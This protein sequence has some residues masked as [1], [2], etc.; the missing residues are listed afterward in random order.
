MAT[1]TNTLTKPDIENLFQCYKDYPYIQRTI[2]Y[3]AKVTIPVK[4]KEADGY[5]NDLARINSASAH[6]WKTFVT[7]KDL[8]AKPLCCQVCFH[9]F[10]WA[11]ER[12][13]NYCPECGKTFVNRALP[14]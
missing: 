6:L 10:K 14:E 8:V 1:A 5:L 12:K 9:V 13:P 3:M 7:D 11:D 4:K 2:A